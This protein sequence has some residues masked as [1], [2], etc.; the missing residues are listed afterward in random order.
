MHVSWK[1]FCTTLEEVDQ[2]HAKL[3][4]SDSLASAGTWYTD[5]RHLSVGLECIGSPPTI[6]VDRHR[7]Q[8]AVFPE[9]KQG[10]VERS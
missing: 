2:D 1:R 8:F 5:N 9:E 7:E 4:P 6:R 10:L 3:D